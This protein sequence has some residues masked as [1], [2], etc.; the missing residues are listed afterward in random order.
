MTFIGAFWIMFT[1][2]MPL[3]IIILIIVPILIAFMTYSNIK[4][5]RAWRSMY[6]N[7]ARVNARVEDAVSGVRVVQSF[8]N[9]KYEMKRYVENNRL[10]R[11]SKLKEYKVMAY[12]QSNIYM[13]MRLMTLVVLI[14]GAWLSFTGKLSYGSLV[15]FVLYVNVLFRPIEKISALLELDRKSTRL[16]SSHVASSYAVFC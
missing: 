4:M 15:A 3:A 6:E 1:I 14:V 8:T 10:F 9:E 5:G 7:I 13:L 2:N 16:N 11:K 12:V